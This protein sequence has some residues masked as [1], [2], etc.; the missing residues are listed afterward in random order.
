[1]KCPICKKE[2]TTVGIITQNWQKGTLKE[3][4]IVGYG[5]LEYIDDSMMIECPEC[6]GDITDAVEE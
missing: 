2:I 5:I 3:N 1:M 6:F 4:K